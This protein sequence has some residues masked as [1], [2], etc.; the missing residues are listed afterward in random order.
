MRESGF[1]TFGRT[2]SLQSISDWFSQCFRNWYPLTHDVNHLVQLLQVLL[3]TLSLSPNRLFFLSSGSSIFHLACCLFTPHLMLSHMPPCRD[4][5][6]WMFDVR[7]LLPPRTRTHTCT[8]KREI[9]GVC[10]FKYLVTY[11]SFQFGLSV[12]GLLPTNCMII[13]LASSWCHLGDV[14]Q[15][16]LLGQSKKWLRTFQ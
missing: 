13:H 11:S 12:S 15:V 10:V 14:V 2:W 4:P 8:S 6:P 9:L 1:W 16:A 5:L 7:S 3:A